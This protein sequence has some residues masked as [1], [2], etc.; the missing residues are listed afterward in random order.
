M[1][2]MS[3]SELGAI[4]EYQKKNQIFCK[5]WATLIFVSPYEISLGVFFQ[6]GVLKR[7]IYYAD[8]FI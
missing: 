3:Q 7:E 2:V 1:K 6:S 8:N 4:P 5:M